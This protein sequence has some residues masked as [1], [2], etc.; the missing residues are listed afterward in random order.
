MEATGSYKSTIA[1]LAVVAVVLRTAAEACSYGGPRLTHAQIDQ[2]TRAQL[3]RLKELFE[4]EV[5]KVGVENSEMRV[6]RVFQGSLQ[7]GMVL[8]GRPSWNSC[9][10]RELQVGD[11]GFAMVSFG[12]QGPTFVSSFLGPETVASLRRIG[13]LPEH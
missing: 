11:R 3:P 13:A 12:P 2:L 4:A 7:P 1:L 5:L 10:T 6:T 8:R 9:D